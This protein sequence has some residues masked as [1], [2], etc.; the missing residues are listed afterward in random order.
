MAMNL[1][2]NQ[3]SLPSGDLISFTLKNSKMDSIKP[4]LKALLIEIQES[5]IGTIFE[6]AFQNVNK[7]WQLRIIKSNISRIVNRAMPDVLSIEP[8]QAAPV[9]EMTPFIFNETRI[10]MLDSTSRITGLGYVLIADSQFHQI[11]NDSIIIH[12]RGM[13]TESSHKLIAYSTL[14][15]M[16]ID[17]FSMDINNFLRNIQITNGKLYLIR[18]NFRYPGALSSII[19]MDNNT[20]AH[21]SD[22]NQTTAAERWTVI[23]SCR[24]IAYSLYVSPNNNDRKEPQELDNGV[25]PVKQNDYDYDGPTETSPTPAKTNVS[26]I[27][28]DILK[29]LRY[30]IKKDQVR[31]PRTNLTLPIA[32]M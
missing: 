11:E 15:L 27:Y 14:T 6:N 19:T 8:S 5:Q 26:S 9:H 12:L 22:H 23:C 2:Y 24:E 20:I 28:S 17:I 10:E 13:E 30:F 3:S 21:I 32:Q 16:G 25:L 29:E 1:G 18:L 7:L 4:Y 31:L